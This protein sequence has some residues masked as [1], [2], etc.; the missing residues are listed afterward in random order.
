MTFS[1]GEP[2][3][4]AE[5][6]GETLESLTGVHR[7]IETSGFTDTDTYRHIYSLLDFIIQDIKIFDGDE[8]R[9]H[10]GAD[11]ADILRNAAHLRDGDKPFIIRIPLI[12]GVTDTDRNYREIA[13]F[14]KGSKALLRVELLP[15]LKIAGAKYRMVGRDYAPEDFDPERT[16][17]ID[18]SVF[19]EVNIRSSVL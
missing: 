12:P 3:M 18:Q 15:Y 1:G 5:F 16:V 10:I 2:L 8:H 4:Q 9:K 13:A 7:A 6:L 17:R 19:E 14:L 11:N